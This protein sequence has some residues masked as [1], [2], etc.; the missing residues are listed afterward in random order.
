MDKNEPYA[1]NPDGTIEDLEKITREN[2][3][4]YY[5]EILTSDLIDIFVIGDFDEKKVKQIINEKFKINTLKKQTASHY[6][7]QKKINKKIK[8]K[9]EKISI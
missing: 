3:Y 9:T 7:K 1:I 5:K 8:T 4:E 2:L 6:V